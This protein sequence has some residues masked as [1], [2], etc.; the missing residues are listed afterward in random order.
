MRLADEAFAPGTDLGES[1]QV[2]EKLLEA[3]EFRANAIPPRLRV[4]LG[5]RRL[6]PR[7]SR[8]RA[9]WIGPIR[10]PPDLSDKVTARHI[11]AKAKPRWC[12]APPTRQ[13]RRLCRR[14]R[15]GVRRAGRDQGRL[16]WRWPRHEG[17]RTIED[18]P[19]LIESATRRLS[20]RRSRRVLRGALPGPA[21]HGRGAGHRRHPRP[22][23]RRGTRDC[24]RSAASRSSSRRPRPR[25][26]PTRSARRSTS[27][28]SALQGGRG[29]YGAGMSSTWSA[30]TA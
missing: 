12:P 13:G 30:R 29:Y 26:R 8:R 7:P 5:E 22:R 16:R 28:P 18:I 15:P 2:F 17:R 27:P 23:R 24:S 21:R 9:D 11:A 25:S 10:V 20:P 3:R 1:N 19:E 6:T 4:P 14:V